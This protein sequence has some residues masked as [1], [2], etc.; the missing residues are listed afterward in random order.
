MATGAASCPPWVACCSNALVA[1]C[2]WPSE[3]GMPAAAKDRVRAI[4]SWPMALL[5]WP[6]VPDMFVADIRAGVFLKPVS[7]WWFLSRAGKADGCLSWKPPLSGFRSASRA[8][9]AKLL[10]LAL[11]RPLSF[12]ESW[13]ASAAPPAGNAPSASTVASAPGTGGA[14]AA[15]EPEPAPRPAPAPVPSSFGARKFLSSKRISP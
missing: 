9:D 12:V 11:P 6:W 14:S 15:P 1:Y 5:A 8:P 3:L 10:P 2:R 7:F 13:A 4:L